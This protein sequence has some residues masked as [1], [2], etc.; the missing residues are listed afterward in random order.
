MSGKTNIQYKVHVCTSP[1]PPPK[2]KKKKKVLTVITSFPIK[3]HMCDLC[4]I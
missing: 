4:L 1:P 2:K 3:T